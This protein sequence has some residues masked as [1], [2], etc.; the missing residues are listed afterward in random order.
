MTDAAQPPVPPAPASEAG[1]FPTRP[2]ITPTS[3]AKAPTRDSKIPVASDGAAG[4]K[5]NPRQVIEERKMRAKQQ[6]IDNFTFKPKMA[7]GG[8]KK[9][10]VKGD[11]L[12][13][14]KEDIEKRKQA[15]AEREASDRPTFKPTLIPYAKPSSERPPTPTRKKEVAADEPTFTPEI[16]KKAS[17]VK[18]TTFGVPIGDRLYKHGNEARVKVDM[19]KLVREQEEVKDCT[20]APQLIETPFKREDNQ[21]GFIER[22]EQYAADRERRHAEKKASVEEDLKKAA[23]FKP[24]I[25]FA[26]FTPSL[27]NATSRTS[28]SS[29]KPQQAPEAK[30]V[31]TRL[32]ADKPKSCQDSFVPNLDVP[33]LKRPN[34]SGGQKS[35]SSEPCYERTMKVASEMKA[36]F[37]KEA[38]KTLEERKKEL[39]FAPNISTSMFVV[40]EEKETEDAGQSEDVVDRLLSS[41]KS[42]EETEKQEEQELEKYTLKPN[43]GTACAT[44]S[45]QPVYER[46]QKDAADLR[47]REKEAYETKLAR[48]MEGVTFHPSLPVNPEVKIKYRGE[49]KDVVRRLSTTFPANKESEKLQMVKDQM[50]AKECTFT[51]AIP[52]ASEEIVKLKIENKDKE[53]SKPDHVSF[54]SANQG[55]TQQTSG[56][57]YT[58]SILK[59]KTITSA[60][61]PNLNKSLAV[62]SASATSKSSSSDTPTFAKPTKSSSLL[63]VRNADGKALPIKDEKVRKAKESTPLVPKNSLKKLLSK[64]EFASLCRELKGI[65][66]YPLSIRIVVESLLCILCITVD[67]AR[68]ES[69]E[70]LF[71]RMIIKGGVYERLMMIEF[72]PEVYERMRLFRENAMYRPHLVNKSSALAG[73]LCTWMLQELDEAAS[74]Y[75]IM[76]PVRSSKDFSLRISN[77]SVKDST[78]VS[79]LRSCT[80]GIRSSSDVELVDGA[81]P[82]PLNSQYEALDAAKVSKSSTFNS[83]DLTTGKATNES[84][85]YVEVSG[86]N[87]KEVFTCEK[88]DMGTQ[89]TKAN[90]QFKSNVAPKK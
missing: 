18:R 69:T 48:E 87:M 90:L 81:A 46:L 79:T 59:H 60:R 86:N 31:F 78:K 40:D 89:Q 62:S 33:N 55:F 50:D 51:P 83:E 28:S 63:F 58:K 45:S 21:A 67:K 25:K 11:L 39:T 44:P 75:N 73:I 1:E 8:K 64:T 84:I 61:G 19:M 71:R 80:D 68:C 74:E 14:T 49:K 5:L 66:K 38:E 4:T 34:P 56:S 47:K 85:S 15:Q 88:M 24:Q 13:R 35:T 54:A 10:E 3:P 70:H 22:M 26:N 36:E 53:K 9:I 32:A 57:S 12:E 41:V 72:T 37:E 27:E 23:T 76:S 42:N 52:K 16:S 30:D 17:S 29:N 65:Q 77:D 82:I 6:E 2:K 7:A 20:F 43:T